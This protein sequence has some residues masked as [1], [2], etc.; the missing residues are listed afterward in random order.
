[1]DDK[2]TEVFIGNAVEAEF[3]AKV[4][5]DN[6]I[7][8]LIRDLERESRIAGW[9]ADI[10]PLETCKVF[11]FEKDYDRAMALLKEIENAPFDESEMEGEA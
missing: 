4:L 6:N 11:V 5:E 1:M 9:V 2:I 3:I 10:I 8:Y 7:E